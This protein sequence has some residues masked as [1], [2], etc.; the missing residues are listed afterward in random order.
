MCSVFCLLIVYSFVDVLI[1]Y[2][3]VD[4]S[5]ESYYVNNL[6][7]T[8]IPARFASHYIELVRYFYNN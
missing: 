4:V 8:L 5:N 6:I 3:F 2:S 1:V 7:G